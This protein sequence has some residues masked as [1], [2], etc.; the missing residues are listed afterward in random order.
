MSEIPYEYD[1]TRSD[2]KVIV[3]TKNTITL[4]D[5]WFRRRFRTSDWEPFDT[6]IKA[7]REIRKQRQRPAHAV[8]DNVFNQQY[9][10]QQRK[11]I[12]SAYDAVRTIR[13]M[14]ANHRSCKGV[15]ASEELF[16]GKIWTF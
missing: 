13:L 6:A 3:R 15:E 10:H 11:L 8:D 14:F 16:E 5:E 2:G 12:L 1:E 9:I 7:L 4:L